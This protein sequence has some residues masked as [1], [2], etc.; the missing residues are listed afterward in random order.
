MSH[1]S[2]F[3]QGEQDTTTSSIMKTVFLD[4]K[5]EKFKDVLNDKRSAPLLMLEISF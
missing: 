5:I 1:I 4:Y 3:P 2:R